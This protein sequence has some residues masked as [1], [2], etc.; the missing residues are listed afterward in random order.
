MKH[1]ARIQRMPFVAG[2]ATLARLTDVYELKDSEKE[3]EDNAI[4]LPIQLTK[5]DDVRVTLE[6]LDDYLLRKLGDS[7]CPL[8]Y[9][10]RETVAAL[11][12]VDVGFDCLRLRKK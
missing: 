4:K 5:I 11:P 6:D 2:V 9:V 8:T 3:A 10:T 12:A 1:L 7:D